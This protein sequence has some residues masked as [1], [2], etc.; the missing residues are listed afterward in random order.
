MKSCDFKEILTLLQP[1]KREQLSSKTWEISGLPVAMGKES[2]Q[3]FIGDWKIPAHHTFRQ[4][5]RR[6]WIVRAAQQPTETV[7]YQDF[8]LAVIKEATPR[9]VEH[10]TE[11]FQAPRADRSVTFVREK[12]ANYPKSWAGIV[13]GSQPD[14]GPKRVVTDGTISAS[15]A[16]AAASVTAPRVQSTVHTHVEAPPVTNPTCVQT[17]AIPV[18][19]ASMMA[20]AIEAA[21]K[22]MKERLEATIMPMQRTLESLQSEFVALRSEEEHDLMNSGAATEA[23]R[24]RLG[25]DV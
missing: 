25:T 10:S 18:D 16:S 9:R 8:G 11:R 1:E 7:V 15:I 21:L 23:K 12:D 2:L 4:G 24:S 6:T 22:P 20:A 13:A 3:E 5:F 19:F 17:P 14:N